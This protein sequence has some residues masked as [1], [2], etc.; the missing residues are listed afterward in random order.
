MYGLFADI[1]CNTICVSVLTYC[2]I[3]YVSVKANP[4]IKQQRINDLWHALR[5]KKP[6]E[7]ESALLSRF[8]KK[9]KLSERQVYRYLQQARQMDAPEEV[10]ADQEP[11]QIFSVRLPNSI[12]VRLR[13]ASRWTEQPMGLIIEQALDAKL[14]EIERQPEEAA[15]WFDEFA[16]TGRI[17]P[18]G[19]KSDS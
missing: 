19:W 7:S 2:V 18:A 4:V 10:P 14:R 3:Q 13:E 15:K 12:L 6:A 8:A 16:R 11:R 5:D 9:H 1:P 17:P